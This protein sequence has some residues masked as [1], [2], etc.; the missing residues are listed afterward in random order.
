MHGIFVKVK[1]IIIKERKFLLVK[2]W[3][4]DRILDPFY[5][6][7]PECEVAYGESPE[8]AVLRL[9]EESLGSS[10]VIKKLVYT[11]SQ[12]IGDS[13]CIGIAYECEIC[14]SEEGQFVLSEEMG[15]YCYAS[16]KELP[17]YIENSNLLRDI[18]KVYKKGKR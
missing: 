12:M 11:W 8:D 18:Q 2:K 16:L 7:F 17:D 3:N 6:E 9:L 4:D 14:D 1:A 15:G 10:G 5:W 13:Q